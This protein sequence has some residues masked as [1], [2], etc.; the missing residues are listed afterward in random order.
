MPHKR[1]RGLKPRTSVALKGTHSRALHQLDFDSQLALDYCTTWVRRQ[2]GMSVPASG[3]V[4]R[5]LKQYAHS[6]ANSVNPL[7]EARAVQRS[8]DGLDVPHGDQLAAQL[9]LAAVAPE[10][11]MPP[12]SH[13]VVGPAKARDLAAFEARVDEVVDTIARSAWGRLRGIATSK[14]QL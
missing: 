14:G 11:P 4:R 6:L 13:V 3:V 5:A 1:A 9:R 10:E 12:F 2:L 8:C 7:G